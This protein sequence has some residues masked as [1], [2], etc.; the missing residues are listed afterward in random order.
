MLKSHQRER[1]RISTGGSDNAHGVNRDPRKGVRVWLGTFNTAEEAA[2]A[3]D[4]EARRIKGKKAKVNF[5]GDA[6]NSASKHAGKVNL[7]KGLPKESSDCVQRGVNLN[8]FHEHD[9]Q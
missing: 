5:L 3:Y 6:P 8:D 4:T 1:G 2:R 9:G 7:R